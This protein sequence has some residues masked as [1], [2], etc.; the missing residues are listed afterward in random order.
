MMPLSLG[1]IILLKEKGGMRE[2]F[3]RQIDKK[4]S[5]PEEEKGV[6]GP[7]GERGLGL[8]RRKGQIFFFILLCLSQYNKV[9]CSRTCFSLA[10]TF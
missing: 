7:Q 5:V 9:S 3:S 8:S 1:N 4:S 6:Q 10:R 2:S